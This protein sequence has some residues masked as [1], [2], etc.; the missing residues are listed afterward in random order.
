M[1]KN[2]F[3]D[4]CLGVFFT[5]LGIVVLVLGLRMPSS[6]RGIGPGVYPTFIAIIMIICGAVVAIENA[7]HGLEIPSFVIK[8]KPGMLRML[9]LLLATFLYL[10]LLDIV[11]FL[12]LS[13]FYMF[14]VMW[15]YGQRRW[16]SSILISILTTVI[17]YGVFVKLFRIFLPTGILS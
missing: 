7:M 6:Q 2:S 8:N 14:F 1:N 11:G 5:L 9:A 3:S 16:K 13:P 15:L 10:Y 4:F 17:L 12:L